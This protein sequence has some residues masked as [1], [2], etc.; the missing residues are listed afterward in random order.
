MYTIPAF[1]FIAQ[2]HLEEGIFRAEIQPAGHVGFCLPEK[3]AISAQLVKESAFSKSMNVPCVYQ[4]GY[5]F[6]FS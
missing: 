3:S 6:K 2:G 5:L 4:K 1:L